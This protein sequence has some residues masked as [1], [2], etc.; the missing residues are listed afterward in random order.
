[1]AIC[2]QVFVRK[3]G[4]QKGGD[5]Y[6]WSPPCDERRGKKLDVS[7]K[8]YCSAIA[9]GQGEDWIT[10]YSYEITVEN[11]IQKRIAYVACDYVA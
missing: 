4:T 8:F 7:K 6:K 3:N 11:G 1:M 9:G 2:K 5:L 10:T